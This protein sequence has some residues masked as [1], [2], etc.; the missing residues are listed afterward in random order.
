MSRRRRESLRYYFD[1]NLAG[2]DLIGPLKAKGVACISHRD[3]F[4]AGTEDAVWIPAVAEKGW[5]IVTRD[6]AIKSNPAER[7]AWKASGAVLLIIRGKGLSAADMVEIFLDAYGDG[8]LDNFIH[9]RRPPMILYLFAN[10][11]IEVKEGGEKRGGKP[12]AT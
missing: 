4:P 3:V 12:P 10:K 7:A 11:R 2:P 9:K 5:V 1:E 8:W 6:V